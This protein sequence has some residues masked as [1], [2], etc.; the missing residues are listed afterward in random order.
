MALY[1]VTGPTGSGKSILIRNMG[2]IERRPETVK[3]AHALIEESKTVDVWACNVSD[4]IDTIL[5]PHAERRYTISLP[6][7]P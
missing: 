1:L 2:G 5:R 6:W 7:N 4:R 3:A